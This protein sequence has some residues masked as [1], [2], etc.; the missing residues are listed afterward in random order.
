MLDLDLRRRLTLFGVVNKPTSGWET[1][2]RDSYTPKMGINHHTA[3][4]N[5]P[6]LTPSMGVVIGGRPGLPGPLCNV[7]QSRDD[8]AWLIAAGKANHGGVGDWRGVSGNTY[9]FGLEIEYSGI[10]AE[11]FSIH[12]FD[13]A[14][15]IQAAAGYGK[16]GA[17][18]VAQH[19]QYAKPAG[20]KIDLLRAALDAHGG[21]DAFVDRI[22]WYMDHP[23]GLAPVI[24][25]P[26]KPRL[27]ETLR[28]GMV[29]KAG[30]PIIRHVENLLLWDAVKRGEPNRGPGR[31]DG[32]FTGKGGTAESLVY[33]RRWFFDLQSFLGVPKDKMLFKEREF[34]GVPQGDYS[35]VVVGPKTLNA[36][37]WAAAA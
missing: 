32:K 30:N 8:I 35:K 9:A 31:L 11:Y 29:D 27:V 3:S 16:Y 6:A 14:A 24:V 26:T 23:P 33:F 20:R 2:G 25:K 28:V 36:L 10:A 22:A 12:R 7:L 34:P 13:T 19:F 17:E 15:R 37:E 5:S 4:A 18:M 1:R 21:V